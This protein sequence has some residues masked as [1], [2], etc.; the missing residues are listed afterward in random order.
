[1]RGRWRHYLQTSSTHASCKQAGSGLLPK[2]VDGG[3]RS[4]A[5]LVTQS[6]I[7]R[8]HHVMTY[9]EQPKVLVWADRFRSSL[10]LP[11]EVK[12][13]LVDSLLRRL[14]LFMT[15]AAY[16]LPPGRPLSTRTPKPPPGT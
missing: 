6:R 12:L 1:M 16:Q 11:S 7:A 8:E 5:P 10:I 2:E 15:Q 14:L 4:K 13:P 3:L 9:G